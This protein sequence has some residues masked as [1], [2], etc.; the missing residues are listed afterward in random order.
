MLS[1]TGIK[2]ARRGLDV[3]DCCCRSTIELEF[4]PSRVSCASSITNIIQE[5]RAYMRKH[6]CAA[7]CH[8]IFCIPSA[9]FETVALTMRRSSRGPLCP[10]QPLTTLHSLLYNLNDPYASNARL[11]LSSASI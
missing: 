4:D 10:S 9:P 11:S 6:S 2:N 8:G 7:A 1:T 5:F 3:E